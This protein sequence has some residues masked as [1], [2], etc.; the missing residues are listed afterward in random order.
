MTD[1]DAYIEKTKARLDEWNAEIDRMEAKLHGAQA[2]AKLRY[3]KALHEMR[4]HR[5]QAETQLQEMRNASEEAWTDVR[6]GFD[7]AWDSIAS[8][9]RQAASRFD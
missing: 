7:R 9:F 5:N 3:E 6:G 1:R 2:D 4:A 8:A